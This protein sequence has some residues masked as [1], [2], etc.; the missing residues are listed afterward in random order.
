MK[1]A[2]C[3]PSSW[4]L[5]LTVAMAL[6]VA[7]Q[8]RT[9]NSQTQEKSLSSDPAPTSASESPSPTAPSSQTHPTTQSTSDQ[10]TSDQTTSDQTTSEATPSSTSVST[11]SSTSESTTLS[12]SESTSSPSPSSTSTSQGEETRSTRTTPT[13]SRSRNTDF[14]SL[15][16]GAGIP[17]YPP[18]TVPPTQNAP[19]MHRSRMPE[20]TVFIAVGAVL[21][22]FGLGILIWRSVV[23]FLLHRSVKRAA[24]AQHESVDKSTFPAPPAP[25]YKYTDQ[26]SDVSFGPS[27]P[28]VAGRGVRRTNR[29]PIPSATPSHTNLFFS[30]TAAPNNPSGSRGSTYLPSGFYTP[31]NGAPPLPNQTNSIN[32]SNLR[33]DSRGRYTN[34]SRH[35]IVGGTPPDSPQSNPRR[36]VSGM[37]TSSLNL[38]S[39]LAGQRAPSAY[40]EDLL[41]DDPNSFP[42]PQMPRPYSMA[43]Y[44]NPPQSRF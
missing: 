24:L 21:G 20:G 23:S 34:A 22:A 41:A 42:P 27:A 35:T 14:P 6:S 16:R 25:F 39:P 8:D 15:T 30:P 31:G 43:G 18:P 44:S 7:A 9:G 36:D 17:E 40:L 1:P 4:A 32:L 12:I 26:G 37:S 3:L 19:F 33:P 38:S 11:P 29:A 5:A 13:P 2:K 10:K 28:V